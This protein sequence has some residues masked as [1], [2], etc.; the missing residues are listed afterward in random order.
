[1]THIVL[2]EDQARLLTEG[3][4]LPV[5][6]PA[7]NVVG[8]VEPVTFT[9]EEIAAAR[10]EAASAGP[11]YTGDDVRAHLQ[12]LEQALARE[13]SLDQQRMHEVLNEARSRQ[14]P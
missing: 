4:V 9:P 14:T 7:G 12:A 3:Q 5:L 11:W 2:S 10:R 8:R 6:N 1:M 13:G